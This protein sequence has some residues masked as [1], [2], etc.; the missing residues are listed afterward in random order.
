[1][2]SKIG[3]IQIIIAIVICA[4]ISSNQPLE[5]Q[6]LGINSSNPQATLEVKGKSDSS[7]S[8]T[9][10]VNDSNDK[11][12]LRIQDDGKIGLNNSNPLVRLDL[13]G[14]SSVASL[15]IGSTDK[16]A[17]DVGE[18]AIRYESGIKEV[19]YSTGTQ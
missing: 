9:L 4:I 3:K 18:G 16:S 13:R 11:E 14:T 17:S 15:G 10:L 6:G 5:A 8:N 7:N 2:T 1:M 19:H 12:L